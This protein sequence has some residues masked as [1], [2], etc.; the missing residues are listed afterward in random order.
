MAVVESADDRRTGFVSER[1]L[2]S[3]RFRALPPTLHWIHVSST[4]PRQIPVRPMRAAGK[5]L[6]MRKVL[7][8]LPVRPRY[9]NLR[10]RSNVL[11]ALP[12]CLRIQDIRL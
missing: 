7:L 12:H 9:P 10:R 4:Q 11:W 5:Q 6:P 2:P 1:W 3:L 8:S